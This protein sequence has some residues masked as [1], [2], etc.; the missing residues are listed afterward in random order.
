MFDR[1]AGSLRSLVGGCLLVACA[2]A[3]AA[4]DAF[5]TPR[6]E[7]M[8]LAG[9]IILVPP[10]GEGASSDS[11]ASRQR[12]SAREYR[13]GQTA[14][15]A[16]IVVPEDEGGVMSPRHSINGAAE[17][18]ARARA[19]RQGDSGGSIVTPSVVL[20]DAPP[21]VVETP[22]AQSAK[23]NRARAIEYR[24]GEQHSA[25]VA[26]GGDGLP[27]VDCSNVDNVAGR[28]GDDTRSGSVVILIQDRNQVKVR[29]R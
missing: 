28:I 26:K 21:A 12:E 24:R 14:Q 3:L 1:T 22:S 9:E 20:P 10:K 2:G 17:N 13:K 29:C 11:E 25:V 16:V 27:I 18:A 5:E 4:G 15:P 23:R 7:P 6:P 19:A 8:L